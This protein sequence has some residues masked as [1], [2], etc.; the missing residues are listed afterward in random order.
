MPDPAGPL[1][2]GRLGVQCLSAHIDRYTM[3]VLTIVK[4]SGLKSCEHKESALF[5]CSSVAPSPEAKLSVT[6]CILIAATALS[7]ATSLLGLEEQIAIE[8]FDEV[9]RRGKLSPRVLDLFRATE[10]EAVLQRISAL[11]IQQLP[12]ILPTTRNL[13]LGDKPKYY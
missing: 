3:P 9:L 1:T 4:H 6:S 11:N 2:L 5:W 13:W 8:I 7:R 12:P 10:H